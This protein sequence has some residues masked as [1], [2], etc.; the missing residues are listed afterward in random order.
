[1]SSDSPGTVYLVGAGPGDPGLI[2]V[3][4][5]ECLQRADVVLYDYL[6]NEALLDHAPA[7]ARRICLG[8][9]G[10]GRL[11]SPEETQRLIV[12]EATAGKTVVRLKSGDPMVFGRTAGELAAIEAAGLR[13]EIV[14][15]VTAAAACATHAAALLTSRD[16]SSAVAL[17]TGREAE[18]AEAALDFDALARFPGSLVFYMGVTS[19][20]D[21]TSQLMAHGMA[22]ETPVALVRRCT[23]PD[24]KV[25]HTKLSAA[26]ELIRRERIRPPVAAIV[27]P[28]G[29]QP[30]QASWFE[31]RPLFGV[32]VL[33]AR[34]ADQAASLA[35]P[36]AEL[37]ARVLVQPAISIDPPSDWS[38][39]DDA[40]ARLGEF[41]WV[42]F[43]SANGVR[44]FLDRLHELGRDPRALATCRI[45][46]IGPG[47][48]AAL[49]E[50]CLNADLTPAEFRAES[51]ASELAP[52]AVGSRCLLVRASRGRDVLPNMLIE[53][54]VDVEQVVAYRSTDVTRPDEQIAAALAAGEIDYVAVTSSAIARSLAGLFGES[55]T[56]S[57]LATISPITSD[58]VREAGCSP[59]VEAVRY[60]MPGLVAAICRDVATRRSGAA[61]R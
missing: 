16:D 17:V 1:M 26:A 27:G 35:K 30:T 52:Q 14:P 22:S 39:V 49:R 44:F 32:S 20:D 57:R 10:A 40:V 13:Y 54:G 7:L 47:T 61:D 43:S 59:A 50:F 36:L 24:Q 48:A 41:A 31:R 11:I 18:K 2:T 6:A 12:E 21:W 28:A 33:V 60:D 38:Q 58:A 46:A 3:R 5:V 42:V 9:H 34:P 53:A 19:A 29:K 8:R 51:L 25:W 45:A 55:L 15:G 37:G 56:H 4:G 23:Y